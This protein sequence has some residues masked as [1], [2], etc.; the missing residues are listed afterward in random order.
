MLAIFFQ[1]AR[2]A[3][4]A[5]DPY[6]SSYAVANALSR[7]A[8]GTLIFN[9]EYYRFSSVPFYTAYLPYI[10]N[11]AINTSGTDPMLRAATRNSTTTGALSG[12][13]VNRNACL[14]LHTHKIPS[15]ARNL[16]GSSRLCLVT[17][18]GGKELLTNSPLN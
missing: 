2:F 11:G 5:F 14:S 15:I 4:V 3:L 13:G 7:S 9:G 8:H 17:A 16:T 18:S 6:L 10:L 12:Y 1:A